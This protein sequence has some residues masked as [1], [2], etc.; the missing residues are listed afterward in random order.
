[1]ELSNPPGLELLARAVA[2]QL[3]AQP[4]G[5]AASGQDWRDA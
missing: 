5:T 2:E 3:E 1:M 4:G